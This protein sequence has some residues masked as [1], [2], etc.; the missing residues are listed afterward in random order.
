MSLYYPVFDF[1]P[2][3]A[4]EPEYSYVTE[5]EPVAI[6]QGT[7]RAVFPHQQ[8]ERRFV[9]QFTLDVL[10]DIRR[11]K[12]FFRARSGMAHPFFLPSWRNDLPY[13]SGAVGQY[14]LTVAHGTYTSLLTGAYEDHY[15]RQL[16]IWHPGQPV[17]ISRIVAWSDPVAGQ[18]LLDL[19]FPLPFTPAAASII[20]WCHLSRFDE[21]RL[22]WQHAHPTAATT[23]ITCMS[24]RHWQ[25]AELTGTTVRLDNGNFLGFVSYTS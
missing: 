14:A 3:F 10:A 21:D 12:E 2:D 6:A 16:F 15:A 24:V 13:V 1:V 7:G 20:G 17:F 18:T 11:A 23:K 4:S 25:D 5:Q 19:E 22:Q 9:F 8:T